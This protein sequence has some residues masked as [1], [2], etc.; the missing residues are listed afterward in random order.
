MREELRLDIDGWR[1]CGHL[2]FTG[3]DRATHD[4]T[5]LVAECPGEPDPNRGEIAELRW[6][7]RHALPESVLDHTGTLLDYALTERG[8][9]APTT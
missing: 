5:C 2:V 1:V 7:S 8:R 6:F 9:P 4:V 3:E